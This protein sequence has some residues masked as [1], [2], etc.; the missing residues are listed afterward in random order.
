M[1]LPECRHAPHLTISDAVLYDQ[2]ESTCD[3]FTWVDGQTY[4]ETTL[5]EH[6]FTFPEASTYGCDS[7]VTLYLTITPVLPGDTTA[8]V[9]APFQWYEHLCL[10]TDDY[11]HI[12]ENGS[13][14]GCD[15]TVTLHLTMLASLPGDTT[16]TVCQS[17][18]WYDQLCDTTGDY[19]HTFINGGYLGNDS[20]VILHLTVEQPF[21]DTISHTSC[22]YFEWFGHTYTQPGYHQHV[23]P[24]PVCDSTF[25]LHLEIVD[26]YVDTLNK[27]ACFSYE[28]ND[29]EYTESGS[30]TETFLSEQGC[31]ST[32]TLNLTIINPNIQILGYKDI[33]YASDIWHGIYHYYVV[34][35]VAIPLAPIE[36]QCSNPD[37]ILLRISDYQCKLIATAEG[38]SVLTAHTLVA[39]N[40][41][42]LMSIEINATEY[43]KDEETEVSLFPNPSRSEVKVQ[44]QGLIHVKLFNT[45]GQIVRDI[46]VNST[47]L[48][49]IDTEKLVRGVYLVEITTIN[50]VVLKRMIIY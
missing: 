15:S 45:T 12:F 48:I 1:G 14:L 7:I 6:S 42:E 50:E 29:T 47:D 46:P 4:T 39:D 17:L 3:A 25:V 30:Y 28:W 31:D 27:T 16:A 35:S 49:V 32:V 37:W 19:T 43:Y 36:W 9:A 38:S 10:T 8:V 33:Y 22:H 34:D 40:C 44:A 24:G 13:Y 21:F 18:E 2:Y 5:G 41:D 11:I 26:E 20:I 23:I